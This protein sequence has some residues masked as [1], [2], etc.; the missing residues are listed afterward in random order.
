MSSG[1]S[2]LVE[3]ENPAIAR[4][5]AKI[6]ECL[7][8]TTPDTDGGFSKK[9]IKRLKGVSNRKVTDALALLVKQRKMFMVVVPP[10]NSHAF[11][12]DAAQ[13][14]I[15]AAKLAVEVL[16]PVLIQMRSVLGNLPIDTGMTQQQIFDK[17]IKLNN[18]SGGKTAALNELVEAGDLVKVEKNLESPYGTFKLP[19]MYFSTTEAGIAASDRYRS[20][21]F[22]G[23]QSGR[24]FTDQPAPSPR[25]SPRSEAKI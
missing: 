7:A 14:A 23:N 12:L 19:A 24:T 8:T 5:A 15:F 6:M 18:W 13:A 2:K 11:F 21:P 10:K 20:A 22:A 3:E 25:P 9:L 16:P 1:S 4:I 17:I